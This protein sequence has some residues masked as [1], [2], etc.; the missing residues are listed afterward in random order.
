[1]K[2]FGTEVAIKCGGCKC[3]ES[4]QINGMTRVQYCPPQ[5]VSNIIF[6]A[7]QQSPL[8][9][10]SINF[11]IPLNLLKIFIDHKQFVFWTIMHFPMIADVNKF[12]ETKI[13]KLQQF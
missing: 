13:V 3:Y 5:F 9:V 10:A 8:E 6:Y 1:M 4:D 7:A 12:P 2:T 11:A